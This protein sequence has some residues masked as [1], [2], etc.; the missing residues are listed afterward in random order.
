MG[1]DR[2]SGRWSALLLGLILGRPVNC[3]LGWSFRLFNRGFDFSTGVYTRTVSGLL[4]VSLL[5]LLVYGGLLVLTWCGFT[6]TPTGFI[7]PQ[8]KGYLLVNV[9]L[10]DAASV[11]RTQE[12]VRAD[13]GDRPEDPRASSTRSPSPGQ[14]ILLN[15]NASNF[16]ALY[17]MLDDFENRTRAG[18]SGDAIAAA[19]AGA[20]AAGGARG[21]REHFGAPPV[22][23]LGTAGGFKIIVQDTR[24]HRPGRRCRKTPTRW[25]RTATPT[26]T[27]R[28]CSPASGPTRPGW[29]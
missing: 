1:P 13:R 10:P 20:A 26:R 11:A 29:S 24:R 19:L 23:G 25:S 15:A 2:W 8:D 16:G 14:S 27:C 5:V 17:L 4:R 9:Q 21:D 18:L 6:H 22:E 28:A 7:P 3:L 12:V